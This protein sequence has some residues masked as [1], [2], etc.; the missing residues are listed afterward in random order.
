MKWKFLL[1]FSLLYCLTEYDFG[2]TNI[3]NIN[4]YVVK[5]VLD[6]IHEVFPET[7]IIY[8]EKNIFAL[9]SQGQSFQEFNDKF[10]QLDIGNKSKLKKFIRK[11]KYFL[12]FV[13]LQNNG[14][15][16]VLNVLCFKPTYTKSKISIYNCGGI[17]YQFE[18]SCESNGFILK[19]KE[20]GFPVDYD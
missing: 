15:E 11:H 18:Y 5:D 14:R 9:L 17:K 8:V 7:K 4:S 16:L 3:S 6:Y 1:L 2:Q 20:Y 12:R 19:T 10:E 13:P